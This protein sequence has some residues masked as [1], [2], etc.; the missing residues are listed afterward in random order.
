MRS[1]LDLLIFN[2]YAP[3]GK[4]QLQGLGMLPLRAE[5]CAELFLECGKNTRR[6]IR[7]LGFG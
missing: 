1:R 6:K 4:P 3:P 2:C 5:R 7:Q